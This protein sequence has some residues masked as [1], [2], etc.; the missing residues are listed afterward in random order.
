MLSMARK[1]G[2]AMV[3]VGREVKKR[4]QGRGGEGRGKRQELREGRLNC[5]IAFGG[6]DAPG[7]KAMQL[8]KR[9]AASGVY[10]NRTLHTYVEPRVR[11][12]DVDTAPSPDRYSEVECRSRFPVLNPSPLA[13]DLPFPPGR[14]LDPRPFNG[15]PGLL[16]RE[17]L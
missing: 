6:M 4:K 15:G 17:N 8:C 12:S 3:E 10:M 11:I 2:G 14:S 16:P 13:F 5:V 9:A 7:L 1:G